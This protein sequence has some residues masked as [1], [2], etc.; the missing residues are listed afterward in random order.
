MKYVA[1]ALA[2]WI[3]LGVQVAVRPTADLPLVLIMVAS[4]GLP[5]AGTG[6]LGF[7]LGALHGALAGANL[8]GYAVSRSVAGFGAS[9]LIGAGLQPSLATAA[10]LTAVGTLFSQLLF[11]FLCPPGSIP[12]FLGD[13]MGMAMYNGVLAVPIYA[14]LR[15]V[16]SPPGNP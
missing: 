10:G 1:L 16:V 9:S 5:R 15:K 13:T 8:M 2:G 11:L 7:L 4:L 6:L 12:K 3:L 14:L